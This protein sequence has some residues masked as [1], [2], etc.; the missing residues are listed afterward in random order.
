MHKNFSLLGPQEVEEVIVG[1][2]NLQLLNFILAN[3]FSTAN[4]YIIKS[5]KNWNY[6]NAINGFSY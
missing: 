2:N 3:T 1:E 6:N 5:K 4:L